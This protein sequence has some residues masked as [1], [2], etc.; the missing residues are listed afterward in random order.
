L[1]NR[2]IISKFFAFA[3]G[4]FCV[5]TAYEYNESSNKIINGNIFGTTWSVTSNEYIADFHKNKIIGILNSID[6]LAS[7]YK[8]DSE[9]AILNTKPLNEE[10]SISK[11]LSKL[12]N[13]ATNINKNTNGLYD[14]T[15]GKVSASRG[16]SPD[17][18]NQIVIKN[19]DLIK[20]YEIN[21]NNK[22]IK[23]ED[24]WFDLSSIA[25][26]YAVDE[27][28][29]YLVENGFNNFLIDIGGEIIINGQNKNK[30][31]LV[32]IQDP[33]SIDNKFITTISN[34]NIPYMAIAT[35][36]EYRNFNF[37]EGS[38][39]THTINPSTNKSIEVDHESVTIISLNSATNADA[40]ATALNVMGYIEGLKYADDNGIAV[41]FI[42]P[43]NNKLELIKS[44]KWYDLKV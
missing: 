12:I 34:K 42:V 14:I 29:K 35:S 1:L 21:D 30:P 4:L 31:W 28:H 39:V 2:Q 8:Q 37:I 22:I 24:F 6:Y 15:L 20:K 11:E 23:Y 18:N 33:N 7:N 26:G 43:N 16:F 36:G 10:I 38:I 19:T 32:G 44:K 40:Y 5:Y 3:V 9:V 41:M 17:F 27:V 25:K 13:I